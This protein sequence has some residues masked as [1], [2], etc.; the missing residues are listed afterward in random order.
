MEE[1]LSS[2]G[3]KTLFWDPVAL[4]Q[5]LQYSNRHDILNHE[6]NTT[7]SRVLLLL[8]VSELLYSLLPGYKGNQL[9]GIDL[10]LDSSG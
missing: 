6:V 7:A 5:C 3:K 8:L 4:K 2:L 9:S 1:M 10:N